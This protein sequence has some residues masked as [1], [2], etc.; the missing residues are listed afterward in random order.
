MKDMEEELTE[1]MTF[2]GGF[3]A[4]FRDQLHS[5]IQ[6]KPGDQGSPIPAHRAVL[7]IPILYMLDNHYANKIDNT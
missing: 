4:A 5:D 6:L 3:L 2:L 1:K 7:V